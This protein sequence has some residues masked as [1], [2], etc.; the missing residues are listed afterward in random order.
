MMALLKE[1]REKTQTAHEKLHYHPLL[2]PL[3]TSDLILFD[4]HYAL[5]AFDA[6]YRQSEKNIAVSIHPEIPNAPV[7][8]WLESDLK[9][10][11]LL[12]RS[13]SIK[14]KC[15]LINTPSKLMG[16]LYVKQG[17]TLGG[18][19]ISK[20]LYKHLQLRPLLDQRFFAAYGVDN[21]IRWQKFISQLRNIE[22]KFVPSELVETAIQ[23]FENVT[24]TCNILMEFKNAQ[25]ASRAN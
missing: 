7:I 12:S 20:N 17:S 4:Y 2:A 11:N 6:F 5:L 9:K 19:V 8:Q 15:I 21:G 23:T 14:P 13:Q 22:H 3:L 18:Q 1:L 10:Q 25:S 24:H 16:Y